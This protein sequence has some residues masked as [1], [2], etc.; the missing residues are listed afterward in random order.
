MLLLVVVV[1]DYVDDENSQ[2]MCLLFVVYCVCL[3]V[4]IVHVIASTMCN[5]VCRCRCVGARIAVSS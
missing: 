3:D 2:W 5:D 1:V 4:E